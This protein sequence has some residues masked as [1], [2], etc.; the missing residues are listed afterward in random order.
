[1][2]EESKVCRMEERAQFLADSYVAKIWSATTHPTRVSVEN[3]LYE[4]KYFGKENKNKNNF[5]FQ[6][7]SKVK[8]IESDMFKSQTY[9]ILNHNAETLLHTTECDLL[10][11]RDI[12]ISASPEIEFKRLEENFVD[13][14]FQVIY[15]DG[16]KT[17][18]GCS[19]GAAFFHLNSNY[20][21]ISVFQ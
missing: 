3:Y 11:G 5:I 10:K 12:Q 4:S 18:E 1:M 14:D 20:S 21:N 15:T 7:A 17:K 9:N 13:N 2:I 6:S 16:S 19:V 8:K